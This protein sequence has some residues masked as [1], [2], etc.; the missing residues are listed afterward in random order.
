MIA[1]M[2]R[3]ESEHLVR[4][5]RRVLSLTGWPITLVIHSCEQQHAESRYE[6]LRT[7]Y[8]VAVSSHQFPPKVSPVPFPPLAGLSP[9]W[10][11]TI[12]PFR[13]MTTLTPLSIPFGPPPRHLF[14]F[15]RPFLF[16]V[17]PVSASCSPS[18]AS[19]LEFPFA[20]GA[21]FA[22]V[23]RFRFPFTFGG[24]V[25]PSVRQSAVFAFQAFVLCR[26][27][28]SQ[29]PLCSRYRAIAAR[30]SV[31]WSTSSAPSYSTSEE[32]STELCDPS[33]IA[34]PNSIAQSFFSP[35]CLFFAFSLNALHFCVSRTIGPGWLN[36]KAYPT[37]APSPV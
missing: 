32:G 31:T 36:S 7:A 13:R 22:C 5:R 35:G 27:C 10:D 20:L 16:I 34:S 29:S 24:S 12:C 30:A 2:S 17:T 4:P 18:S 11:R 33:C 37:S 28:C 3:S 6:Y 25:S 1:T 26:A 19:C 8:H 21:S 23:S 15:V 9:L 14:R